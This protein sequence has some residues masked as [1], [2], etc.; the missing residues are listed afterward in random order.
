MARLLATLIGLALVLGALAAA[1]PPR[2]SKPAPKPTSGK[3][4]EKPAAKM[5]EDKEEAVTF[6]IY[7]D[8]SGKYRFR[9]K[10]GDESLAISGKGYESKADIKKA[11]D[12]I[13][14]GAAK[15]KI[16]EEK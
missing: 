2:S 6:D 7:K 5:D 1:Q 15:A 9:L 10:S 4:S 16:H 11:I 13:K 14:A 3:S 12:A 8:N